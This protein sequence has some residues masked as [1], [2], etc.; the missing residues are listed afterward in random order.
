MML[1]LTYLGEIWNELT[2]TSMIGQIWSLPL[3]VAM[4]TLNLAT[5]NKWVLYAILLLLL[6]YPN[7]KSQ[8]RPFGSS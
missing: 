6:S 2:F 8:S 1:A 5:I 7:G 4:V 3:L